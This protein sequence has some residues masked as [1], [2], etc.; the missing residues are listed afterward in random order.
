MLMLFGSMFSSV[1][2]F[3]GSAGDMLRRCFVSGVSCI[4]IGS[5]FGPA[6]KPS[7]L[8]YE[9]RYVRYHESDYLITTY[10]IS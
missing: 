10:I 3:R 8:R 6:G 2:L 4:Y 9:L 1:Q 5:L 7:T